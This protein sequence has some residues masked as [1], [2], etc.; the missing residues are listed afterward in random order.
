M[1]CLEVRMNETV[2]F[3]DGPTLLV[4]T[5]CT[6][7]YALHIRIFAARNRS[8]GNVMF[9]LVS[10]SPQGGSSILQCNGV[11]GGPFVSQCNGV[12]G[13]HQDGQQAGGTHPTGMHTCLG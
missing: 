9:L 11:E 4:T 7:L 6:H 1:I 5:H 8:C 3:I 2:R 12:E 10:V 13:V